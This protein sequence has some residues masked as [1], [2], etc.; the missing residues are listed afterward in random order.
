MTLEDIW[1]KK[2]FDFPRDTMDMLCIYT[3]IHITLMT[4]KYCFILY[5]TLLKSEC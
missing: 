3:E 4:I 2:T 5:F 1:I